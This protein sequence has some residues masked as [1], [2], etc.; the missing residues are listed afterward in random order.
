MDTVLPIVVVAGVVFGFLALRSFLPGSENDVLDPKERPFL[1][2]RYWFDLLALPAFIL[3]L[4]GLFLT[5]KYDYLRM[6]WETALGI[7]MLVMA[8]AAFM[9]GHVITTVLY[10]IRNRTSPEQ[11][12]LR[13]FLSIA[14][15]LTLLFFVLPLIFVILVGPAAIQ[16]VEGFR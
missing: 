5:V 7:K 9:L 11:R 1:P 14:L 16:I 15:F 8:S 3:A 12:G 6:L 2:A 4:F 13:T 10:I